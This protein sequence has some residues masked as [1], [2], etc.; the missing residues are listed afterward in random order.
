MYSI[1]GANI[2]LAVPRNPTTVPREAD[3]ELPPQT[4]VT[5]VP[6]STPP[7]GAVHVIA[8]SV[9]PPEVLATLQDNWKPLDSEVQPKSVK[10]ITVP[11]A[12]SFR[13]I[14]LKLS[15]TLS[16]LY[17]IIAISPATNVVWL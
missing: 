8:P 3:G 11:A 1:G 16:A 13:V 9:T 2:E 6:K 10:L 15:G 7:A 12:R 4:M 14:K 17:P 5:C